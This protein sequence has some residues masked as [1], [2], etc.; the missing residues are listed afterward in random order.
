[1]N[2]SRVGLVL[3]V[4]ALGHQAAPH[5][6]AG[7]LPV[8]DLA[9]AKALALEKQ[10]AIAAARASLQAAIA[11]KHALDNLRV[12]AFLQPDLPTRR[13]QADLG[14]AAGQAGV[15]LAEMNTIYGVQYSYITYLFARSQEQ[16]ADDALKGLA[17]LADFFTEVL[18][19]AEKKKTPPDEAVFLPADRER[20]RALIRLARGRREEARA[21]AARALSALREALGLEHDCPIRLAQDRLLDVQLDLDCKALVELALCHRPEIAQASIAEQVHDLEVAAQ[22]SRKRAPRLNTFAAGSD[23]HAHPLPAGSFDERYRPQAVGPEM[24]TLLAGKQPD[25]VMTAS[26]YHDRSLSVLGKTR[27]L[28]RLEVEQ[29]CLRY[30]EARARLAEIEQAIGHSTKA[31]TGLRES[32]TLGSGA[33]AKAES[34]L[35]AAVLNSQL[36]VAANEARY[37][38]LLALIALE[39]ATAG[40]FCAGLEKAGQVPPRPAGPRRPIGKDLFQDKETPKSR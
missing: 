29:A 8:L 17:E 18:Q 3:V 27:N 30:Q 13:K 24:P 25:R 35:G 33:R 28:V 26:I 23:L 37:E 15:V 11:R 2:R 14:P 1:M 12:P 10:P 20:T 5:S 9:A 16:L 7:E 34:F 40:T 36:R 39:R 38:M 21:G 4:L 32:L 6:T 19:D 22:A 31:T